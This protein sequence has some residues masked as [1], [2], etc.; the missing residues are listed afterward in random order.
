MNNVVRLELNRK[1]NLAKVP[2]KKA[3]PPLLPVTSDAF[4]RAWSSFPE[5]GRKRSSTAESWPEWQ[6]IS[7]RLGEPNLEA[8][9][10][11][12][13]AST[14]SRTDAGAPGFHRWLKWARWEHYLGEEAVAAPAVERLF[15][16]AELRA[17]FFERFADE[18][19]RRWLD[20]CELDDERM[21][22]SPQSLKQSWADG[23]CCAA[24]R[25]I[26]TSG[27]R[28]RRFEAEHYGLRI[29]D[30]PRSPAVHAG[31][32]VQRPDG[33]RTAPE[34]NRGSRARPGRP[35]AGGASSTMGFLQANPRRRREARR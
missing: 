10:A 9:V 27:G 12:Y 29:R 5:V 4:K 21:I 26:R 16:D 31:P 13:A 6:R 24:F 17:K 14:D 8:A 35:S 2:R 15:P 33:A 18:R 23:L 1:H 19:A 20:R 32:L 7:A 30:W 22:V 28:A 11:R 25:M 3:P 34:S